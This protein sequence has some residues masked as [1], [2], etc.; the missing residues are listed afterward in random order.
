MLLALV[1]SILVDDG[2]GGLNS[3]AI[4]GVIL[5]FVRIGQAAHLK[6]GRM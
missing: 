1:Y 2:G 6:V 4:N 3:F 5:S